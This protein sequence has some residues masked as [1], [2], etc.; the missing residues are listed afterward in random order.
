MVTHQGLLHYLNWSTRAYP[1]N[2]SGAPLLSPL[3]FDLTVTSLFTPLLAAQ[4]VVLLPAGNDPDSLAEEL[5]DRRGFAFVKLTPAHLEILAQTLP[6]ASRAHLAG[7]LILGGE[8][9]PAESLAPWRAAAPSLRLFNEYGPTEAVVGCCVYEAPSSLPP[10]WQVP[11][12]R[13]IPNVRLYVLDARL[14]PVPAGVTGELY[15]AGQGLARGYLDRPAQTA[16]RF[17]PDSFSAL[18]G[19]RSYR[20]GDLVRY[21]PDGNLEFIGRLDQQVKVRGFRIEPGEIEVA[22]LRCAGVREAVVVA[23]EDTPGN[24]KLVAYLVAAPGAQSQARDLLRASLPPHMIPAAFVSL[25]ALPLTANG[26]LDRRALPAPAEAVRPD[27]PTGYAAPESTA[28]RQ[29]AAI[30]SQVLRV[31][32][33]GRHDNFFQ[34]GGDSILSIQ[35]VSRASRAGLLIT[36]RQI[37]EHQTIAALA[38][39]AG[40]VPRSGA[41]RE[42]VTGEWPLTPAQCWFFAAEPA[43]P[44]HYNQSVLLAGDGQLDEALLRLALAHL[45]HHHDALRLRFE[46]GETGWRQISQ[47]PGGEPPA[48]SVDLGSLPPALR[49]AALTAAAAAL[50]GSL[51]LGNG[52]LVRAVLFRGGPGQPAK[53]LLALHHLAVDGVSWRI[54]LEDLE[55]AYGQLVRGARVELP[56][57]T[58]SYGEWAQRLAEHAAGRVDHELAFWTA[59][60]RAH[61]S[62]LPVDRTGENT[63]STEDHVTVS[64]DTGE[65]A[66]LLKEVPQAYRTQSNDVL[67]TALLQSFAAWTGEDSLLFDLEGHGREEI[68]EDLNLARTVGWFTSIFPML[69]SLHGAGDP[70]DALI[71]IKEQLRA[72][73]ERGIGYGILRYLAGGEVAE[74]LRILPA[75]EVSFNYLGQLDATVSTAAPFRPAEEPV[76]PLRSPRQ[77]RRYAIEITAMVFGGRLRTTFSYSRSL[78]RRETVERLAERFLGALRELV[79]HCRSPWARAVT[80][81]DF[82]LLS[83]SR[84]QLA[85]AIGQVGQAKG[86]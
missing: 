47:P 20:T 50:Q 5:R 35:I 46:H 74:R 84:E 43:D 17:L 63:V 64:L 19:S 48:A 7:A 53:L 14:E 21:R 72:V 68:L 86:L 42:A 38:A 10:G 56:P 51:D 2:G 80:P 44:H 40:A 18:P 39:A 13:P 66:A 67:L 11:I 12:G 76:G 73:P 49:T 9:L 45:L 62:R 65:T 58:T 24:K 55:T 27:L 23:R 81:S 75:A 31:E 34:L 79:E 85:K 22:L 28:E 70:G 15:I 4:P 54:F 32:P 83:L 30:W 60:S 25:D 82:P 69:L 1:G 57:A 37:F 41:R 33:V 26:K 71:A 6:A 78:H 52:P 59:P 3:G 36:A 29:L 77:C 16:E 8:A 61:A